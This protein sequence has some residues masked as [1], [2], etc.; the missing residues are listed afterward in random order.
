MVFGKDARVEWDKRD[1]Y[2]RFVGQVMVQPVDCPRCGLTLDAGQAQL[3]AG[4]A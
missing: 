1:R 4:M 2:G 3:A